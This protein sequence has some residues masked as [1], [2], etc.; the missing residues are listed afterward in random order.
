VANL[1]FFPLKSR[2]AILKVISF[3][4]RNLLS[5]RYFVSKLLV[6]VKIFI[7]TIMQLHVSYDHQKRSKVSSRNSAEGMAFLFESQAW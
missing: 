3:V 4:Q 2:D 5:C 7:L 1:T 6:V